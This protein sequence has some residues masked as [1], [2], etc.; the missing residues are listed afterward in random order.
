MTKQTKPLL[1]YMD[2]LFER[3]SFQESLSEEER[4]MRNLQSA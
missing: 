4:D 3:E 1:T 2:L